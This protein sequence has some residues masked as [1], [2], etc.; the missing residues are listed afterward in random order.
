MTWC[1]ELLWVGLVTVYEFR[2]CYRES[3]LI[4]FHLLAAS[5]PDAMAD[6]LAMADF[7]NVKDAKVSNEL[8]NRASITQT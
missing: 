1:L 2:P 8:G 4:W 5:N 6:L 7:E 3:M